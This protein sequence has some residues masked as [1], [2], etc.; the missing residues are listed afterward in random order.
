MSSSSNLRL[1]ICGTIWVS[2][3][4]SSRRILKFIRSLICGLIYYNLLFRMSSYCR[5][6]KFWQKSLHISAILFCWKSSTISLENVS[7]ENRN[8]SGI[9][10]KLL[11][12]RISSCFIVICYFMI[13]DAFLSSSNALGALVDLI[14]YL[15][16]GCEICHVPWPI[17]AIST[18]LSGIFFHFYC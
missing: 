12:L 4:S 6:G 9:T 17:I 10:D 11:S 13:S 16:P 3:L 1:A 14:F 15:T 2:L 7:F 18:T 5:H 8:V